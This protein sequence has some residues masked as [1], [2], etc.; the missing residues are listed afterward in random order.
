M[1]ISSRFLKVYLKVPPIVPPTA[2][3]VQ[4]VELH[5]TASLSQAT[6]STELSE[7]DAEEAMSKVPEILLLLQDLSIKCGNTAQFL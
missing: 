5:H 1:N 4:D 3:S 6:E 7:K 2:A